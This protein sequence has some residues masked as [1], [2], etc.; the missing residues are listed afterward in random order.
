MYNELGIIRKA[1]CCI[2]DN[3][4][5]LKIKKWHLNFAMKLCISFQV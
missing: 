4:L 1:L 3:A 2:Y 5:T